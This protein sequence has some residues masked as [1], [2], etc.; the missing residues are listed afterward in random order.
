MCKTFLE[1]N[2]KKA[3]SKKATLCKRAMLTCKFLEA[4]RKIKKCI[5]RKKIWA[6]I[7]KTIDVKERFIFNVIIETLSVDG[8]QSIFLFKFEKIR[9]ANHSTTFKVF[10]QSLICSSL[11]V[12]NTT[13][14]FS[15]AFFLFILLSICWLYVL[16]YYFWI[17]LLYVGTPYLFSCI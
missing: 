12:W 8:S 3:I 13:K 17:I 10:V 4:I 2:T 9:K 6:S 7:D 15:Q 1:L 11:K 16:T 14:N 5:D